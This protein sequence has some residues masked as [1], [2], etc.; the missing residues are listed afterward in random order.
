MEKRDMSQKATIDHTSGTSATLTED[1]FGP[2]WTCQKG[3]ETQ[4]QPIG[5]NMMPRWL[6][7]A[8]RAGPESKID[9][10]RLPK[11]IPRGSA[12]NPKIAFGRVLWQSCYAKSPRKS[13]GIP[14]LKMEFKIDPNG[15]QIAY[16]IDKLKDTRLNT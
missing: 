6:P 7:S 3:V 8:L 10:T 12:K 5:P 1:K 11:E 13:L 4:R 14:K 16:T 15:T 2:F 9:R